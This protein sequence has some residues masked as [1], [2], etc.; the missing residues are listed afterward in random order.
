MA[1]KLEIVVTIAP[2][3][4]VKL[5]THGLKGQACLAETEA[6]E[7]ALGAVKSRTRTAEWYQTETAVRG[8]TTQR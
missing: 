7:K 6:V 3:G 4:T 2:D 5:E 8:K 1:E